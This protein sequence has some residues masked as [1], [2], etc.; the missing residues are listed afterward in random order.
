MRRNIGNIHTLLSHD[1]TIP[2]DRRRYK[3]LL[4]IQTL[5][6]Q[7]AEIFTQNTHSIE[8]RIVSIMLPHFR[9]IVRGNTNA[10]VEFGA[11]IN[12]GLMNGYFFLDDLYWDAF[13]DGSRLTATLKK[14]KM[15]FGYYP[16][17]V[18]ANKIFCTQ[19]QKSQPKGARQKT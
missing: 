4:V 5:Y 12:A 1:E 10:N 13:N 7:Q 14:Y 15:R 17:E 16:A 3:D 8:H 6:D 11:K 2:L 18:L 19:R 9:P